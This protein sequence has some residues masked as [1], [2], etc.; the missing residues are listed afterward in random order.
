MKCCIMTI[1]RIVLPFGNWKG[2]RAQKK[3]KATT[4]VFYNLSGSLLFTWSLTS[5]HFWWFYEILSLL[6]RNLRSTHN[7]TFFYRFHLK[8]KAGQSGDISPVTLA[9]NEKYYLGKSW[10]IFRREVF[11]LS[12]VCNF[13]IKQ[14]SLSSGFHNNV[15]KPYWDLNPKCCLV[16]LLILINWEFLLIIE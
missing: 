3:N 13:F 15:A 11:L 7:H 2:D 5:D 12:A 8:A 1:F 10:Y 14:H 6:T 9:G 4:L 16:W